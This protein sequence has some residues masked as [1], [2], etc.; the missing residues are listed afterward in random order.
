[1]TDTAQTLDHAS[2]ILYECGQAVLKER[3]ANKKERDQ[4]LKEREKL[5]SELE[6]A[7]EMIRNMAAAGTRPEEITG[8][9]DDGQNDPAVQTDPRPTRDADNADE[10]VRF[11]AL[12]H[13]QISEK[14][15]Q[16]GVDLFKRTFVGGMLKGQA[17]EKAI[18]K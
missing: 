18:K 9:G 4:A 16:E 2:Q 14:L 3:E 8:Y 15:V 13:A 5:T 1:M 7:K 11:A 6:E 10:S 12:G 17:I